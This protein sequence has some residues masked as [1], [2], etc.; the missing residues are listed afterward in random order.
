MSGRDTDFDTQFQPRERIGRLALRQ[1]SSD[2]P[3]VMFAMLVSAGFVS[4][5]LM[6]PASSAGLPVP[7]APAKIAAAGD[8][9]KADR[10]VPQSG[11]DRNCDGQAWGAESEACLSAIAKA[12]GRADKPVRMVAADDLVKTT[13]N[14]F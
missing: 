12:N 9:G 6:M 13:P 3:M 4:M 7:G 8:A 14:V 1:R 10:V 5:A 11:V 2:H